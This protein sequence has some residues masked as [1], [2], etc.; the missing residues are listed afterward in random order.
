MSLDSAETEYQSLGDLLRQTRIAQGLE[1]EEIAD[2]TKIALHVLK[3]MEDNAYDKLP[4]EVFAKGFYLLYAKKLQLDRE[5]ILQRF[6]Q[7]ASHQP[8]IKKRLP[9]NKGGQD[10]N[11]MAERPGAT[12]FFNFGLIL[13]A[14]LLCGGLLCW[15]FSWNPATY[16][17]EKLRSMQTSATEE[18]SPEPDPQNTDVQGDD[19]TAI[20]GSTASSQPT[21]LGDTLIIVNTDT[22]GASEPPVPLAGSPAHYFVKATFKQAARVTATIDN[23]EMTTRNFAAGETVNWQ[24]GQKIILTLPNN[25][26]IDITIN[27]LPFTLPTSTEPF[28]TVSIPDDLLR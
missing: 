25:S 3:A 23:G 15:Y 21:A 5:D 6:H 20:A 27:D 10:I 7:N 1:L 8:Q 22:S 26:G 12:S 16:L 9:P 2:D 13:F 24:A 4:S 14:L 18:R 19:A 28:V 17:S 11:S